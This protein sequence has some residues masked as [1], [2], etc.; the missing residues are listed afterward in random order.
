MDDAPTKKKDKAQAKA[1]PGKPDLTPHP[2][3]SKLVPDPDN[4]PDIV[5][6]EGYLG[7]SKR[8]GRVRVYVDLDFRSYFE[9]E[10]ADIVDHVP[11]DPSDASKPWNILIKGTAKLE[12]VQVVVVEASYLK[13]TITSAHMRA[14]N[15]SGG[16]WPPLTTGGPPTTRRPCN[17]LGFI[18]SALDLCTYYECP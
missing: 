16:A 4:P 17:F 2:L 12:L 11:S 7:E 3:V 9:I 1:G 5:M 8:D 6:V 13:G 15:K 18:L 14:A 10:E